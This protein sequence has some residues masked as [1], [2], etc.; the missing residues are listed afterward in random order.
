MNL[1]IGNLCSHNRSNGVSIMVYN[2]PWGSK[3]P[4]KKKYNN[5][6]GRYLFMLLLVTMFM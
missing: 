2:N 3:R 1:K 5:A 4:L 6:I